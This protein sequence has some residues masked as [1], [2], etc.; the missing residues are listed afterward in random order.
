MQ[1]MDLV[2]LNPIDV[3]FVK[4]YINIRKELKNA[5][6]NFSKEVKRK[7]FPLKKHSY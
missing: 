6:L 4:K 3:R 5:V 2:G 1:L 7:K